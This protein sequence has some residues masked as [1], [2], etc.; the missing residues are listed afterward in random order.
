MVKVGSFVTLQ[1]GPRPIWVGLSEVE[2]FMVDPGL[3]A[4]VLR[5]QSVGV[6][7]SFSWD[8]SV[9]VPEYEDVL[10]LEVLE[11]FEDAADASE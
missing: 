4:V 11:G 1:G 5:A 10:N 9:E 6:S 8:A 2:T 7:M 3:E